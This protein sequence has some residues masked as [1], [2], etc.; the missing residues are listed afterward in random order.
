[1][2]PLQLTGLIFGSM[3][4]FMAMRLPIAVSMFC[5][6]AIG[7]LTQTGWGPFSS[8]VNAQAFARFAAT[9]CPSYLCLS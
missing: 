5:A 9:T 1:M 6:G 2:T 8:F 4:L 3:L 7:Y